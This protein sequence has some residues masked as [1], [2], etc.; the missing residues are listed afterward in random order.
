MRAGGKMAKWTDKARRIL[1]DLGRPLEAMIRANGSALLE[2][3]S[4][5]ILETK[6]PPRDGEHHDLHDG[7]VVA[8][9]SE[10]VRVEGWPYGREIRAVVFAKDSE[11]YIGHCVFR[12]VSGHGA[13]K[14]RF[15]LV[16]T[17]QPQ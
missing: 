16:K 15:W 8:V 7:Y 3:I 11:R 12:Y 13:Q 17:I 5:R 9:S 6:Q 14:P 1:H 4:Q 2:H 10:D